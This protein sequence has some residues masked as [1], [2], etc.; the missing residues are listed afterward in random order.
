MDFTLQP[1]C[2]W[3]SALRRSREHAERPLT[4]SDNLNNLIGLEQ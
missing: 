4:L 3:L 1:V 2:K